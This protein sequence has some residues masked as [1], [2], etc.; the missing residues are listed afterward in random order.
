[1]AEKYSKLAQKYI[2]ILKSGYISEKDL[3]ALRSFL[4]NKNR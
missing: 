4:N 1:M 3:I 2:D